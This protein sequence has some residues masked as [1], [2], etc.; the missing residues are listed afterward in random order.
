MNKV[1]FGVSKRNDLL[2]SN[3]EDGALDKCFKNQLVKDSVALC[4][5]ILMESRAWTSLELPIYSQLI[6]SLNSTGSNIVEGLGNSD[7]QNLIRF[8]KIAR[9]SAYESIFHAKCLKH[10]MELEIFDL[11][12]R[13]D[14]YVLQ[15][16]NNI[17]ERM[18]A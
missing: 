17:T 11:A 7:G 2:K 1:A 4:Q 10:P 13:L 3:I 5:N 15:E 9:G 14:I 16:V 18:S 6:R 8:L 12:K